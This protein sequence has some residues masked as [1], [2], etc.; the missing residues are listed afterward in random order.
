MSDGPFADASCSTCP[1]SIDGATA[2]TRIC[3]A[4]PE[5]KTVTKNYWCALHPKR[6]Q[7]DA[8]AELTDARVEI[9]RMVDALRRVERHLRGYRS[10]IPPPGTG[11][12]LHSEVVD[13]ALAEIELALAIKP[14]K[15]GG[16]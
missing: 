7:P 12:R 5:P 14:A 13:R 15:D 4:S 2:S 9:A 1:Y 8:R 11:Q 6:A 3:R 10:P 16:A